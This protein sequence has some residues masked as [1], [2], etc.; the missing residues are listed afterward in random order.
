VGIELI[1]PLGVS[2]VKLNAGVTRPHF[3]VQ[4]ADTFERTGVEQ[5]T[6]E[7]AMRKMILANP[8]IARIMKEINATINFADLKKI[9]ENH[10]ANVR[11]TALGIAGN[12]PFSLKNKVNLKSL[13]EAA[14][15]HDIGKVLIPAAILN[16]PSM[17]DQHEKAV[18]DRHA[19]IGYELLKTTGID[20]RTLHLVRDHHGS[21]FDINRQILTAADKFS[22]LCEER[23]YKP[24]MSSKQALAII[25]NDVKSGALHPFVFRALVG[26]AKEE[27]LLAHSH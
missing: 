20:T 21:G 16:K 18:M 27:Q 23:P 9:Q 5:Y 15:L 22:A 14:Y 19:E 2:G 8:D 6:S 10:A 25:Y 4:Q 24:A 26:F 12:L 13:S 7:T 3:G 17:L 11:N 1:K